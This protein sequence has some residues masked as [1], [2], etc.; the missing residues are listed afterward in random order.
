MKRDL[1]VSELSQLN[2]SFEQY[3]LQDNLKRCIDELKKPISIDDPSVS[4]GQYNQ[5]IK[6]LKEMRE[7]VQNR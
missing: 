6:W 1:L 3:G 5:I 2:D 7:V 4:E